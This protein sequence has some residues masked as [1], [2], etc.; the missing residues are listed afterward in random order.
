MSD[1]SEGDDIATLRGI[2]KRR[3]I[4]WIAGELATMCEHAQEGAPDNVVGKWRI[5]ALSFRYLSE[6]REGPIDV[7]RR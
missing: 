3:G 4:G 1:E 6:R 2:A 5:L 7:S